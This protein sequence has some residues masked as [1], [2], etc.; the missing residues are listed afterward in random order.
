LCGEQEVDRGLEL[1]R[2][3]KVEVEVD[4]VQEPDGVQEVEVEVDGG[5][6]VKA[7]RSWSWGWMPGRRCIACR[8]WRWMVGRDL[9]AGRG[10]R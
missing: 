3:Q 4:D 6:E 1:D 2:G 9:I 5:P 8:S 10:W 7:G